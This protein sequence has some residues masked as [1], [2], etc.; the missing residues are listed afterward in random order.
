MP[1]GNI[2]GRYMEVVLCCACE[3]ASLFSSSFCSY[4]VQKLL[5]N[6]ASVVCEVLLYLWMNVPRYR[7]KIIVLQLLRSFFFFFFK[8]E[9]GSGRKGKKKKKPAVTTG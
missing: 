9:R 2:Y 8:G 4:D 3:I 5:F 6:A 1:T 7:G